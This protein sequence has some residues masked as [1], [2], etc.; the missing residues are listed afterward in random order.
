MG[1]RQEMPIFP[2]KNTLCGQFRQSVFSSFCDIVRLFFQNR[3]LS[4]QG[5]SHPQNR[6][7]TSSV[8]ISSAAS[9]SAETGSQITV[10]SVFAVMYPL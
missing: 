7:Y 3:N 8:S 10:S 5:H 9:Y 4:V 1:K 2:D 6:N